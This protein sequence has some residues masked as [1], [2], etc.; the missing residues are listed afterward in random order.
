[1]QR[2]LRQ[3]QRVHVRSRDRRPAAGG[4]E[5]GPRRL[6]VAAQVRGHAEHQPGQRL[7]GILGIQQ[8]RR[9]PGIVGHL[10][11]AVATQRRAQRRR[12]TR[13]VAVRPGRDR[14]GEPVRREVS[15]AVDQMRPRGGQ[16]EP[17]MGGQLGVGEAAQPVLDRRARALLDRLGHA[18]PHEIARAP[19]LVRGE[20]VIE[21]AFTVAG[22]RRRTRSPAGAGG[23]RGPAR[24]A[25]ARRAA[26]RR[27]GADD[28]GGRRCGRAPP[29]GSPRG[30]G[31]ASIAAESERSSTWSHAGAVRTSITALPRTKLSSSALRPPST[32]SAR[33]SE[34]RRSAP[35]KRAIA[36][37]WTGWP[38]RPRAA[39]ESA[40]GQPS[41]ACSSASTSSRSS[42][43]PA[44]RS[45]AAASPRFIAR[46]SARSSVTRPSARSRASGIG[47]WARD[48]QH[49]RDVVRRV[50]GDRRDDLVGSRG[51]QDVDVVEH[52]HD[53]AIGRLVRRGVDGQRDRAQELAGIV[54]EGAEREP[55]ER[56]RVA[57]GPLR[58][59][60]G[61][62]EP[63]RCDED[64]DRGRVGAQQRRD[65]PG[66][67]DA[68]PHRR[69]S[70]RA[71]GEGI[72]GQLQ[73][74][75]CGH[76]RSIPARPGSA[77]GRTLAPCEGVRAPPR[78][79]SRRLQLQVV[80][81]S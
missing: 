22:G 66:P 32:S 2:E 57:G 75:G 73:E 13:D 28:G 81:G 30:R 65:Q 54:V 40:A 15:A 45:S 58:E 20:R 3:A 8:R 62:P 53:A 38:V 46:S 67:M 9:R 17:R 18:G 63:G 10:P 23:V 80:A 74:R 29:A 78:T 21:P 14:R 5:P 56:A 60:R 77:Q 43:R 1:M 37:P 59:Q 35:P 39:S 41:V 24:A 70:L 68:D 36:G 52:E 12:R 72:A 7:A 26:P 64:G 6:G 19:G 16:G 76:G 55:G 49:H 42:R 61:L 50:G 27:A 44:P 71:A 48:A 33:Y 79:F 25:A 47:G 34:I 51:A 31:S 11:E 4:L 69:A